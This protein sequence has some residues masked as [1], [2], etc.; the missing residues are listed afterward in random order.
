MLCLS[1]LCDYLR[2]RNNVVYSRH[3]NVI[4]DVLYSLYTAE[5]STQND[6]YFVSTICTYSDEGHIHETTKDIAMFSKCVRERVNSLYYIRIRSSANFILTNSAPGFQSESVRP[7]HSGLGFGKFIVKVWLCY[8]AKSE[9]R[10]IF[11]PF[12]LLTS[13]IETQNVTLHIPIAFLHALPLSLTFQQKLQWNKM[14]VFRKI[15]EKGNVENLQNVTIRQ[16]E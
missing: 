1:A 16:M 4:Q 8:Q 7:S 5:N 13:L 9:Y 6:I 2:L 14:F 3:A 15:Y 12:Q 11:V 10:D